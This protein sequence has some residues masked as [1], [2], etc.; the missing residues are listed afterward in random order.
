MGGSYGNNG[1]GGQ[2]LVLSPCAGSV[3]WVHVCWEG[4]RALHEKLSGFKTQYLTVCFIMLLRAVRKKLLLEGS[5]SSARQAGGHVLRPC[6]GTGLCPAGQKVPACSSKHRAVPSP[7][8]PSLS[9]AG[10]NADV[11][12]G[13]QLSAEDK[14]SPA[15]SRSSSGDKVSLQSG[16]SR[17]W[18]SA[19]AGKRKAD[20]HAS[21]SQKQH[22]MDPPG[23]QV[24][25]DLQC[26]THGTFPLPLRITE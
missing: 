14:Q 7:A 2:T 11:S 4:Q 9:S 5:A 1:G 10:Q 16:S 19:A 13:L 25:P 20:G 6:P 3:S 12:L 26:L 15:V 17:G 24:K 21:Q 23:S 18:A 8:E 22:L